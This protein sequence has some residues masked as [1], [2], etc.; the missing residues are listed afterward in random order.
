MIRGG[1]IYNYRGT[2]CIILTKYYDYLPYKTGRSSKEVV[3]VM[4]IT[5]SSQW[6]CVI[7]RGC[8]ISI[9]D[10]LG[11]GIINALGL[12]CLPCS[13]IVGSY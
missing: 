1:K 2:A 9:F 13:G 10:H 11:K 8:D 4:Y 6:I 3:Y 12:L 7:V 5:S